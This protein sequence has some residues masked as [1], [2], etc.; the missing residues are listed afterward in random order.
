[1]PMVHDHQSAYQGDHHHHGDHEDD[2]QAASS[3]R[4]FDG[5]GLTAASLAGSWVTC[6]KSSASCM[7]SQLSGVVLSRVAMRAAMSAVRGRF[8]S[9]SSETV[10]PTLL[11]DGTKAGFQVVV[12]KISLT[13]NL[14]LKTL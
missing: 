5:K 4:R 10:T 7:R 11:P 12:I 1:M 3:A 2:D 14:G 8:S 6:H 13:A 9:S